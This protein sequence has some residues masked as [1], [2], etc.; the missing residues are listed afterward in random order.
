MS[1]DTAW[2]LVYLGLGLTWVA[3]CRWWLAKDRREGRR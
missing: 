1:S 2:A 3:I